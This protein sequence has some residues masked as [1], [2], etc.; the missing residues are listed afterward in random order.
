MEPMV[1]AHQNTQDYSENRFKGRAERACHTCRLSEGT[2][3]RRTRTIPSRR[4]KARQHRWPPIFGCSLLKHAR[5]HIRV[6]PVD[7]GA[8]SLISELFLH[9]SGLFGVTGWTY[10]NGWGNS[11]TG[12]ASIFF[13]QLNISKI[14][15]C[16]CFHWMVLSRNSLEISS[17]E[18]SIV[19][20]QPLKAHFLISFSS[21][22][23]TSAFS[24][25]FAVKN[26]RC[27]SL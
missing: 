5:G 8:L 27:V 18:G 6:P 21:F 9:G 11:V 4:G 15:T 20:S 7:F 16:R 25:F 10:S 17:W 22:S 19:M 12:C 1:T 14:E 3:T 23:W 26:G 13:L 24:R 2:T